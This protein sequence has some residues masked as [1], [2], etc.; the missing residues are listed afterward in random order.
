MFVAA[1]MWSGA[2]NGSLVMCGEKSRVFVIC[3]LFSKGLWPMQE[4]ANSRRAASEL[5]HEQ[6]KDSETFYVCVF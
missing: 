2:A 4:R 5:D 1:R 6:T 3:S